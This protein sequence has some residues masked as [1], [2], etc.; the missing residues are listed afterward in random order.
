M[1][2]NGWETID[3]VMGFS[4]GQTGPNIKVIGPKTKLQE[5]GNSFT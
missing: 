5:K 1:K 3:K 4:I 2:A